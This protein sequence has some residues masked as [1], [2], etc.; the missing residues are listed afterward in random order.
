[1]DAVKEQNYPVGDYDDQ[2]MRWTTLCQ[3]RGQAV[4]EFT[5]T[6]SSLGASYQYVVKIEQK[7]R[8]QNKREFGPANLQ[9]PKYDKDDPNKQLPKNHSKP[10]EKKGHGKT[11]KYTVKWCDFHKIPSHNT[12]E[13]H[14]KQLL[15]VEIKYKESNP[16]S[17]NNGKRHIIDAEPTATVMT[18]TIQPE[19]T[20][21]S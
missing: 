8:H 5:N 6:F 17:E 1:V 13:C 18:T 7:F 11:K 20:N 4:P 19:G 3:E 12:N 10:Q 2:Y 14:S 16:D 9:Q 15:V 21:R